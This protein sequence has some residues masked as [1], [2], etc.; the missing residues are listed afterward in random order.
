MLGV[1]REDAPRFLPGYRNELGLVAADPFTTL[2]PQVREL[3]EV[4]IER[5]RSTQPTLITG[6]CGDQGGSPASIE[7]CERLGLDFV[8]APL[9]RLPGARLAAAQAR[10]R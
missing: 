6:L 4:A 2:D 7:A 8:S 3:M 10:I 1:S 5:G 9:S